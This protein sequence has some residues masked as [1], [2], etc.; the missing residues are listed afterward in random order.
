MQML[1]H[2]PDFLIIS[3]QFLWMM[4]EWSMQR[5]REKQTNIPQQN[6]FQQGTQKR[7]QQR[8]IIEREREIGGQ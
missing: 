3:F 4:T 7:N 5:L 6:R 1:S 8:V 2:H